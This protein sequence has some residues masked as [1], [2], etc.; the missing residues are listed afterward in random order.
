[1]TAACGRA[2]GTSPPSIWPH[3][4]PTFPVPRQFE[5]NPKSDSS[6]TCLGS[7]APHVS[8]QLADLLGEPWT[9]GLTP[10][11]QPPPVVVKAFLLPGKD[12][13]RL[14]ELQ[15]VLLVGPQTR[16]P[17]PEQAI[18]WPKLRTRD[19]LFIDR[20]L[21]PQGDEFHLHRET[22]PEPG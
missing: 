21:M 16:E 9:T 10:L 11:T 1:V 3:E 8:D 4:C 2:D 7:R 22:R 14:H 15:D 12:G 6:A 19:A 20:D 5:G 18:G 13:A 17:D